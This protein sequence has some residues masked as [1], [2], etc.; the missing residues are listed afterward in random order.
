MGIK[1]FVNFNLNVCLLS[2]L[3]R[4]K[5]KNLGSLLT[6]RLLAFFKT[7]YIYIK[8]KNKNKAKHVLEGSILSDLTI[9]RTKKH[10]PFVIRM[11]GQA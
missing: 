9:K 5:K 6:D 2:K 10:N 11:A 3:L 1:L 7:Y 8:N 4:H